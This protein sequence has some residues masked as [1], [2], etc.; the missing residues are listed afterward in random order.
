MAHVRATCFGSRVVVDVDDA[1]EVVCD[2]FRDI[3]ELLEIESVVDDERREGQR[4]E[5]AGRGF[6]WG[7]ILND[8]GAQIGGFNSAEILLIGL[9]CK[10]N[11][12]RRMYWTGKGEGSVPLA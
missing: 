5:I 2:D 12:M 4:G 10:M 9:G 3:V 6:I 11:I 7:G 8:F 1:I